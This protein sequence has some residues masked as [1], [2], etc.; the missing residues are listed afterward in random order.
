[1]ADDAVSVV[2]R[3]LEALGTMDADAM[4]AEL[5]DGVVVEL[6]VAPEGLPK[7]IEGKASFKEFFGPIA[8]GLWSSIEFFDLDIRPEADPERIVAQY[9]S[10]GTFAN[11]KPYANVYLNLFRVRDGKIVYGAEYF[12]PFALIA[13]LTPPEG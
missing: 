12:D 3:Y 7:R 11:G 5:A 13:G 10:R 1:M 8:A 2:R 4:F 6:P 9:A